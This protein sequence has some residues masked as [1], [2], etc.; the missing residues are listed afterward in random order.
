MREKNFF[1][2]R[3]SPFGHHRPSLDALRE[4]K[5]S[6]VLCFPPDGALCLPLALA[7]WVLLVLC[8]KQGS[9]VFLR[10][11]GAGAGTRRNPPETK[12]G[13]KP[14]S[15]H[16]SEP[17]RAGPRAAVRVLAHQGTGEGA[18]EL[19]APSAGSRSSLLWAGSL[20]PSLGPCS[21]V[22]QLGEGPAAG[23]PGPQLRGRG[24]RVRVP[25]CPCTPGQELSDQRDSQVTKRKVLKLEGCEY[26]SETITCGGSFAP[27]LHQGL[28]G[29]P[30]VGGWGCLR[31]PPGDLPWGRFLILLCHRIPV[32]A[33]DIGQSIDFRSGR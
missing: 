28:Q 30:R 17:G 24:Q 12:V 20:L 25:H 8:G 21:G 27:A 1:N 13:R 22:V 19:R 2:S 14:S 32:S 4:Y 33:I 7:L 6:R 10:A 31:H 11:D 5:P 3:I 23:N 29:L 16:K 15:F 26:I 9:G 18:G